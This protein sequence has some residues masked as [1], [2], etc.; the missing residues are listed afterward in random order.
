MFSIPIIWK[1]G[2]WY[3]ICDPSAFTH[4]RPLASR[5]RV[6]LS[7]ATDNDPYVQRLAI[8]QKLQFYYIINYYFKY[9][10]LLDT[11]FLV[12][13]KKNLGQPKPRDQLSAQSCYLKC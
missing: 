6:L 8:S 12:L 3:A 13:K 10:E 7:S 4:V 1:Q 9:Y 5:L 11:V 2:F